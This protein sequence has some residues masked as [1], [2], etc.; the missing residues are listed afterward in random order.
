LPHRCMVALRVARRMAPWD[1]DERG[2][3]T[4]RELLQEAVRVLPRVKPALRVVIAAKLIRYKQE[5]NATGGD[6]LGPTSHKQL[7][8][9]CEQVHSA[10]P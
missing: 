2:S 7:R 8:R 5:L 6:Y 10:K 4:S 1:E 3:Y 9:F